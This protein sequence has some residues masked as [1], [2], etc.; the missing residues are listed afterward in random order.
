MPRL[1]GH[2]VVYF[3]FDIVR[4]VSMHGTWNLNTL[5][6]VSFCQSM[7]FNYQLLNRPIEGYAQ[8]RKSNHSI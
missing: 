3:D 2:P 8:L 4:K 7:E 1:L 5:C 6:T